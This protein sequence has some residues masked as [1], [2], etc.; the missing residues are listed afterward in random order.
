MNT[1]AADAA[2]PAQ[3]TAHV[4]PAHSPPSTARR[5]RGT[6]DNSTVTSP[7]ST[8][9]SVQS[10][11]D[12]IGAAAA[13]AVNDHTSS[14][15]SDLKSLLLVEKAYL[16]Q[17]VEKQ[18][19]IRQSVVELQQ[20][21]NACAGAD[22]GDP[23]SEQKSESNRD[24]LQPHNAAASRRSA[25]S[26]DIDAHS[27]VVGFTPMRVMSSRTTVPDSYS[28][29]ASLDHALASRSLSEN[30]AHV[31]LRVMIAQA[32]ALKVQSDAEVA[33]P[34]ELQQ[35][36]QPKFKRATSQPAARAQQAATDALQS[37][38]SP[39][40]P[41]SATRASKRGSSRK[42]SRRS[43]TPQQQQQIATLL[44]SAA[45]ES[46]MG[47]SSCEVPT[48]AESQ[49]TALNNTHDVSNAVSDADDSANES[50]ALVLQHKRAS[51]REAITF[52][53]ALAYKRA[54]EQQAE[55]TQVQ[56]AQQAAQQAAVDAQ[57]QQSVSKRRGSVAALQYLEKLQQQLLPV[58]PLSEATEPENIVLPSKASPPFP[59]PTREKHV[60]FAVDSP[61]KP[62]AA[63]VQHVKPTRLLDPA[64][65][66]EQ[67]LQLL[68]HEIADAAQKLYEQQQAEAAR[69][70]ELQRKKEREA[71]ERAEEEKLNAEQ[72]ALAEQWERYQAS[73][74]Q[75]Q[76]DQHTQQL[77]QY[78]AMNRNMRAQSKAKFTAYKQQQLQR[79]QA[80]VHEMKQRHH[81]RM[82]RALALQLNEKR[83]A[84][85]DVLE[86]QQLLNM[87][88]Q[89]SVFAMDEMKT[90][91]E[92]VELTVSEQ[93]AQSILTHIDELAS[94]CDHVHSDVAATR[95]RTPWFIKSSQSTLIDL[96][97]PQPPAVE[98]QAAMP[99]LSSS[100]STHSGIIYAAHEFPERVVI[101]D[102]P[103]DEMD[104]KQPEPRSHTLALLQP[105]AT[106]F[107]ST[108]ILLLPQPQAA[109]KHKH[110]RRCRRQADIAQHTHSEFHLSTH[111]LS[112]RGAPTSHSVS[113]IPTSYSPNHLSPSR[114]THV[115]DL[116]PVA[117]LSYSSSELWSSHSQ[118]ASQTALHSDNAG[119][120]DIQPMLFDAAAA[121]STDSVAS[122][123]LTASYSSEIPTA[124]SSSLPFAPIIANSRDGSQ[125]ALDGMATPFESSQPHFTCTVNK[126]RR[127]SARGLPSG[128]PLQRPP[129][130]RTLHSCRGRVPYP[131]VVMRD[132]RAAAMTPSPAHDTISTTHSGG[133]L[134]SDSPPA[135]I[136]MHSA[137]PLR[138][139]STLPKTNAFYLA[140]CKTQRSRT[141][142]R[143]PMPSA[144][145]ARIAG[146]RAQ[147][148][149]SALSDDSDSDA[150]P[151]P[152]KLKAY[153]KM[154]Y[155]LHH[156]TVSRAA[157][158]MMN[159]SQ[160]VFSRHAIAANA[161]PLSPPTKRSRHNKHALAAAMPLSA[162]DVHRPVTA[163][164]RWP[165]LCCS[166]NRGARDCSASPPAALQSQ[167]GDLHAIQQ[168]R[169]FLRS[170]PTSN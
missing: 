88:L 92:V 147:T 136:A 65:Q 108:A 15:L 39:M 115:P 152:A 101:V 61:V 10:S 107:N 159:R 82:E 153:S 32:A 103:E 38:L 164:A 73:L 105:V 89:H 75:E 160:T 31:Q 11:S 41:P 63:A 28:L 167:H 91:D 48:I 111:S 27:T 44:S 50:A 112:A 54:A 76:I 149:S 145:T 21:V 98:H 42:S 6:A 137:F 166:P 13:S 12:S 45:N 78:I 68:Q 93:I 125:S 51:L 57:P 3:P 8:Q 83:R 34:Q 140:E 129:R 60:S 33:V 9:R 1:A 20:G 47:Q 80:A 126:P 5:T 104:S 94:G 134:R 84:V 64:V 157:A 120:L 66:E 158:E 138:S 22:N 150:Y 118:T 77:K 81:K 36:L 146:G 71:A 109:T 67:K 46:A 4:I 122:A 97:Q 106:S 135:P 79:R 85:Q 18:E 40:S 141:P 29:S 154:P 24:E 121:G 139:F 119:A 168:Q 72:E 110:S 114:S 95:A 148:A 123:Q 23:M 56:A 35:L 102:E 169:Y 69:K 17:H 43:A 163:G 155:A 162:S 30:P 7:R 25:V 124:P 144:H 113:V 19:G 132:A 161:P 62:Q 52:E 131:Q 16:S 87:Q 116:P 90:A 26:P 117:G 86:E 58:Q 59:S 170:A 2:A 133:T 96:P 100:F 151:L 37:S 99:A 14:L 130:A 165:S 55:I 127:V 70:A 156:G 142:L 53:Q 143:P 128:E 49:E 74:K